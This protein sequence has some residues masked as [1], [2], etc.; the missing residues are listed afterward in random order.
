MKK[1]ATIL[2]IALVACTMVFAEGSKEKDTSTNPAGWPSEVIIYGGTTGGSWNIFTTVVGEF[3][4]KHIPGIRTT[5]SPGAG[6][7]NVQ[8]VQDGTITLAVSKLP[9]TFD[10]YNAKAPFT[11]PTT[12]VLNMGFLYNE[13]THIIV[14]ADSDIYSIEDLK[15]KRVTTFAKGNTAEIIFRDLLSVYD[16]T[17]DDLGAITFSNLNDMGEQFKDGLTDCLFFASALPVSV[18][19]DI[20][21]SRNI[22]LI[23]IPDEKMIAMQKISPAYMRQIIPAGTY[24]GVDKP[25]YTMGNAQHMIVNADLPDDFV[26]EMTKAIV[27]ELKTIGDGHVVYS[28]L[29]PEAMAQDLGIPMHPGALRYYREI[30]A[31]K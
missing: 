16:M 13:H 15:G 26:Y 3:L 4:P 8:G 10:G 5:V 12:K 18:V 19:L 25:C 17:Y 24:V 6:L 1:I 20:A 30:G 22:R 31:C 2:L 23:D 21:S 28:A 7:S 9:T 14:N 27:E 11:A 29:T